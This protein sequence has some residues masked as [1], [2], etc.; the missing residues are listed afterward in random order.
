MKKV[1]TSEVP[2]AFVYDAP[3]VEYLSQKTPCD[4]TMV[5]DVFSHMNYGIVLAQNSPFVHY[6]NSEIQRLKEFGTMDNLKKKWFYEKGDCGATD[7]KSN[8]KRVIFIFDVAGIFVV[9][10]AGLFLSFVSLVAEICHAA[11]VEYKTE[12]QHVSQR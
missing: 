8:S 11:W 1:D 7:E 4:K 10:F 6:F 2:Y 3:V 12:G 9:F 5:G